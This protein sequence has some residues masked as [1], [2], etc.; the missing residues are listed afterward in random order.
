VVR[1]AGTVRSDWRDVLS[2]AAD[3]ALVGVAVTLAAAPVVTAGAAVHTG[4]R[5]VRHLVDGE[6]VPPVGELWL[7]FR[8]S[9]LAGAA[10]TVVV[11]AVAGL[12]VVDMVALSSGRVPGGPIAIALTG[13]VAAVLA[14]LAG[15]TVV[16]LGRAD[17]AADGADGGGWLA[18]LRWAAGTAWHRPITAAATVAVQALA[19]VLAVLVPATAPLVAGFALF[20]LHVVARR[21]P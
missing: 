9:L 19:I 20:A 13:G 5:A 21:V 18:A 3:L 14:A 16:R 8:R 7:V 4:S 11:L 15:L 17:G 10:A 6:R 1:V 12:L 2:T